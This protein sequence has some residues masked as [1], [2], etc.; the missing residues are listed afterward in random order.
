MRAVSEAFVSLGVCLANVFSCCV[1]SQSVCIL[2]LFVVSADGCIR[3][4]IKSRSEYL[5]RFGLTTRWA[6]AIW[7][8]L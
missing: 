2:T 1:V 8:T 6:I 3:F 5:R 7:V 4:A